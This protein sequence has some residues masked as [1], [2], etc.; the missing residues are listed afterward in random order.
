MSECDDWG[1]KELLDSLLESAVQSVS[2]VVESICPTA[3]RKSTFAG[4]AQEGEKWFL[5]TGSLETKIEACEK[6]EGT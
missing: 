2:V 5:V 6:P 4:F 1:R 3:V